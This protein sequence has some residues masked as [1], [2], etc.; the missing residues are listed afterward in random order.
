MQISKHQNIKLC[1]NKIIPSFGTRDIFEIILTEEQYNNLK[2]THSEFFEK[3]NKVIY[4]EFYDDAQRKYNHRIL[5][6]TKDLKFYEYLVDSNKIYSFDISFPRPPRIFY[7]KNILYLYQTIN[8]VVFVDKFS[9]PL[10]LIN[11]CDVITY[12]FYNNS[13]YFVDNSVPYTV[14][15][16]MHRELNNLSN[17]LRAYY[18]LSL[19]AEDGKI[20]K[21]IFFR[22]KIYA[23]QQYKISYCSSPK[24]DANFYETASIS[25]RIIPNTIHQVNDNIVFMT[26]AG[27][28]SF[29]GIDITQIFDNET[30]KIDLYD[31]NLY[32]VTYN[33][34]YYLKCKLIGNSKQILFKFDIRSAHA[35]IFSDINI[36]DIYTIKA[37]D[38]YLLCL[39]D[40]D[41]QQILTIDNKLQS[42]TEKLFRTE[43]TNFGISELKQIED[44]KIL[45]NGNFV[46]KI[47]SDYGEFSFKIQANK[48]LQNINI[49]GNTFQFEIIS[50]EDFCVESIII[51][52]NQVGKWW[53]KK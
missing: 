46:L 3:I 21:I 42:K 9:E 6:L 45:G 16:I 13:I 52:L 23:F 47:I 30:K 28:F 1:N 49:K 40:N 38:H 44:F 24:L 14:F 18:P 17:I 5:F 32:A 19:N 8:S 7:S 37:N 39:R 20:L 31:T 4:Y 33:E 22:N 34:N 48:T 51:N 25:S 10:I 50:N 27:M 11:S 29:D 2:T 15:H 43:K 41:S 35:E 36:K 12:M 53:I 26:T